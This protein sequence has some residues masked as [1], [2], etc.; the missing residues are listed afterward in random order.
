VTYDGGPGDSG[1]ISHVRT[2]TWV[3]VTLSVALIT[4]IGVI[5]GGYVSRTPSP[6]PTSPASE[7]VAR[8]E[9]P[10]SPAPV[11]QAAPPQ[12]T[13]EPAKPLPYK[14]DPPK[15]DPVD[16]C[17]RF[18]GTGSAPEGKMLWIV[19]KSPEPKFYFQDTKPD[20]PS[21]GQWEAKRVV[22]GEDD[23]AELG[24]KYRILIVTV[25]P[26]VNAN[27]INGDY[28]DGVYPLPDGAHEEESIGVT[29]GAREGC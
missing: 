29:A 13:E 23:P 4:A 2:S 7:P 5:I 16:M 10:V 26:E 9:A 11:T 1:R 8:S 28:S 25:T 6:T 18:T 17:S 24:Q 21:P 27:A 12:A 15:E 20:S 14:I 22:V 19:V 3:I